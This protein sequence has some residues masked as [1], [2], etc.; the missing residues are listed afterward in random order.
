LEG[1]GVLRALRFVTYAV[2]APF[3]P[4]VRFSLIAVAFLGFLACVIYRLMLHDP[5]FPLGP[6]LA[7]S[8]GLCVVSAALGAV[9][10]RL[11]PE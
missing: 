10:R 4:V 1:L 3:E 9:T 2:L 8:I 5:R 6:M 11:G 7:M